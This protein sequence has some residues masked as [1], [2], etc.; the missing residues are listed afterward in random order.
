MLWP[1]TLNPVLFE[2]FTGPKGLKYGE[3]RFNR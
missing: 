3:P 1:K 2:L